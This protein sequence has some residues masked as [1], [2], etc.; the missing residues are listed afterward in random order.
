[1]TSKELIGWLKQI[2]T[3]HRPV[4]NGAGSV[5][6]V[7]GGLL[8]AGNGRPPSFVPYRGAG[9]AIQDLIAGQVDLMVDLSANSLG[10]VRAAH[11]GLW[12]R[13]E[14][15]ADSS[16]RH[17]NGRRSGSAWLLHFVWRGLWAPKGTQIRSLPSSTRR[18]GRVG[19]S[20]RTPR[21]ADLG[22][23][24]PP[25]EQ[26]TPEALGA[27]QKAEIEKWWPIIRAAGIKPE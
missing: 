2:P 24:I 4:T 16:P 19:R 10:Q 20:G 5:P 27:L 22:Q 6:H 11:K 26:Q 9:P 18:C 1:M 25:R 12:R 17:S 14:T 8:R 23:E 21:L 7:V 3:R 15:P 13:S